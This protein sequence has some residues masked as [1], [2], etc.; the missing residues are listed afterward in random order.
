M[1]APPVHGLP[2]LQQL[3]LQPDGDAMQ[4]AVVDGG[5][6]TKLDGERLQEG[7]ARGGRER[8]D[9]DRKIADLVVGKAERHGRC[10]QQ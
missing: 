8:R 1:S 2:R 5:A 4:I 7:R 9:D 6:I 10:L 3:P